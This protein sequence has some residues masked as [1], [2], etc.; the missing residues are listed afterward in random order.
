MIQAYSEMKIALGDVT[1]MSEDLVHVHV[2]LAIFV[3][4]ALLL[5]RRMR[6]WV[7]L[8][9]VAFLAFA[10]ELVDFSA[11]DGWEL[12]ASILDFLNTLLWPFVLFLLARRGSASETDKID[13]AAP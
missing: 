2:G 9:T 8:A 11:G 6:S 10:N 13:A 1:G 3:V 12:G 4:T 5:R 7:P